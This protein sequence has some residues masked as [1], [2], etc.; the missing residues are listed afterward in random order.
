MKHPFFAFMGTSY[1]IHLE[2]EFERILVRIEALWETP[3][4]HDY[5]TDLLIDKRGGRK[6]FPAPVLADII[7]LRDARELQTFKEAERKEYALQEL[8]SLGIAFLH[9]NF[10][11]ALEEGDQHVV[12][13]FVRANINVN[14]PLEDGTP[15]LLFALTR[16]LTIAAQILING[17]AD[18]N[19]RGP[20]G[21]TPLLVAC[22]KATVGY[23]A[24]VELLLRKGAHVNVRDPLGNTPLTLAISGGTPDIALMLLELDADPFAGP[25]NGE[26]PLSLALKLGDE[27]LLAVLRERLAQARS[28]SP[29]LAPQPDAA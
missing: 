20:L 14:K 21:L 17:N 28:P 26:T 6:G 16:G 24:A 13:L 1:P 5:F 10:V 27:E 15:P 12:D 3:E 2:R 8:T 23:R 9:K 18:P 4:I 11:N 25:R 7:R 19:A 29:R 22:G